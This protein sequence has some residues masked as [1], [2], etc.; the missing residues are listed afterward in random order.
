MTAKSRSH[1]ILSR[2]ENYEM[3]PLTKVEENAAGEIAQSLG[4]FIGVYAAD[5]QTGKVYFFE[6][7]L[8]C[9]RWESDTILYEDISGVSLPDDKNSKYIEITSNR[10]TVKIFPA[11]S[12]DIFSIMRYFDRIIYDVKNN[13]EF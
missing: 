4:E 3:R 1:R 7:G 6:R 9:E 2:L 11:K 5:Q 8:R 13:L 10:E 12:G